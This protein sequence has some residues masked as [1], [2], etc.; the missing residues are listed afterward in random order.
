MPRP[1][2]APPHVVA[3]ARPISSSPSTMSNWTRPHPFD[4]SGALRRHVRCFHNDE[5][6]GGDDAL[7][8]QVRDGE[9]ISILNAV[10]GG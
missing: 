9:S 8:R 3:R 10:S 5:Y 1:V 4:E 6:A 2:L 7:T